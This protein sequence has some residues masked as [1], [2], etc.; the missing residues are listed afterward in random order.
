MSEI[1]K[2]TK[3]SWKSLEKIRRTMGVSRNKARGIY[4]MAKKLGVSY[5]TAGKYIDAKNEKGSRPQKS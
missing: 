2:N 1:I 4:N 5:E 3:D